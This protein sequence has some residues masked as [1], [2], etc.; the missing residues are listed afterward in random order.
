MAIKKFTSRQPYTIWYIYFLKSLHIDVHCSSICSGILFGENKNQMRRYCV[1]VENQA[2][3]NTYTTME[4]H[5]W[6]LSLRFSSN[7]LSLVELDARNL[8]Q[9][10]KIDA[11]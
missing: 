2:V 10:Q 3:A 5:F 1:V 7:Y 4:H 6:L 9:L 8:R 11:I